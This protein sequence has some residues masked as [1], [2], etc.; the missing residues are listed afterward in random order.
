[1]LKEHRSV[2]DAVLAQAKAIDKTLSKRDK[3]KLDEYF[4]SIREIETRLAK[5]ESWMTTPK[6]KA[7]LSAPG[8]SLV[9]E[10]E[11]KLMYDLLVA[12][13]Q[14]D[15]TRVVT[16]RQPMANLIKSMGITVAPHD[17][18]HYTPGNRM[19]A[20]KQRDKKQSELL[21]HLLDKLEAVKEGRRVEPARQRLPG[22]RLEHPNDP[23]PRQLP[24]GHRGRR[25]RSE[26]RPPHRAGRQADPP[27]QLWLTLLQGVGIETDSFGDS[28]GTVGQLTA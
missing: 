16:Y 1:M 23:L 27:G 26:A 28:T 6:P 10:Q 12:A 17:L 8:E 9:G 4:Q 22:L 11:V 24:D 3:D 2:L 18:S 15:S 13:F 14:T 20:S 7:P 25:S 21:A 5:E 19:E